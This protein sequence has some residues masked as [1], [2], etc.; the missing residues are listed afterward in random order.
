M[1]KLIFLMTVLLLAS[2]SGRSFKDEDVIKKITKAAEAHPIEG[3]DLAQGNIEGVYCSLAI[4]QDKECRIC[5]AVLFN[6]G[7]MTFILDGNE[8]LRYFSA[9]QLLYSRGTPTAMQMKDG[10]WYPAILETDGTYAGYRI[11]IHSR[12]GD[13]N[14]I[15]SKKSFVEKAKELGVGEII[16]QFLPRLVNK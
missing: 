7:G 2:C 14:V 5:Y 3:M 6:D 11:N 15:L 9:D 16:E 10:Q 1:K 13:Q 8:Y 12:Y 4:T